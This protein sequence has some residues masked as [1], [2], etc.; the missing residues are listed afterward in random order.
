MMGPDP[1]PVSRLVEEEGI[2]DATLYTWRKQARIDEG[3]VVPGNG[4]SDKW[5]AEA[6]FACIVETAS[7]T[8]AEVSQYCRERGLYPDQL[9]EWKKEFIRGQQSDKQRQR[10][11][12][13]QVKKEQKKVKQLEKELK[14]KEKALAETA[15][16][17]VLQK[18]FRRPLGGK[19]GRLIPHSERQKVKRWVDEACDAGARRKRAC[20]LLGIS[21]RTLQRWE[22]G[23][24]VRPDGRPG[25][26]REEPRNKLTPEERAAII[27][28]CNQTEY[29]SLS[30]VQIVPKLA[31]QGVFIASE[32]CF[33]RVL[34]EEGQ[35]THRGR[36]RA[37]RKVTMPTTHLATGPNQVWSWDITYVPTHV[38]GQFFYLY[39]IIDI[40]S[41]KIVG[42]EVH[43]EE[44]GE[45]AAALIQRTVFKE[46][47][48]H[49]PLV[50]HAD[51]GAPMKSITLRQKLYELN[52]TPSHS[53]PMVSND[54]PY[55]ESLF[56]TLKYCP[57]WP[58][59]GFADVDDSRAWVTDFV[60]GYNNEHRHSRIKYVTPA[61]RHRGED[62]EILAR[63]N[64]VYAA[65][66]SKTP[67]RWSGETRNWEPISTVALNPEKLENLEPQKAS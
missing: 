9:S 6:K 59:N 39:M 27:E 8:E 35:L 29:A 40:Y 23:C 41:R 14:R 55:S 25:A 45:L 3:L 33:Y 31:D 38:R 62:S 34:R 2:S 63:R 46:Q 42:W 10:S 13:Q 18:K 54:N 51:N 50:L 66:K 60:S 12:Q 7:L 5:S 17:L 16:L 58:R 53:R 1:V 61:Q 11:E 24:S 43:T 64:R 67:E 26:K 15:A 57:Q 21:I 22:V 56:R 32:S 30:P 37:P 28:V 36:S 48:F 4:N 19:R 65:A 47:C 52:I 20:D 49:K 44:S